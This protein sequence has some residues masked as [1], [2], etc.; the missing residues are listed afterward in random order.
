MNTTIQSQN[1]SPC[2][3]EMLSQPDPMMEHLVGRQGQP[4]AAKL[5]AMQLRDWKGWNKDPPLSIFPTLI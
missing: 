3:A 5:Y 1:S 2:V 4:R